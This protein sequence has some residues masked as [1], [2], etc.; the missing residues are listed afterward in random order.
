MNS[1]DQAGQNLGRML[2]GGTVSRTT[3]CRAGR[4]VDCASANR[5][6]MVKLPGRWQNPAAFIGGRAGGEKERL[7]GSAEPARRPSQPQ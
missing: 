1:R 4:T 6:T 7:Q 5:G 3:G 2:D